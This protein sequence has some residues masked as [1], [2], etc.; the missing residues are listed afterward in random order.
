METTVRLYSPGYRET[1]TYLMAALFIAGNII[2]PQLCHTVPKGGLILLPIYFF[3]LVGSYKYGWLVGML[4]AVLS[5]L[6]NHLLFG[7]PPAA[8]LLPIIIKSVSLAGAAAFIARRTGTATLLSVAATVAIYQF[9]GSLFEWAITGSLTAAMQDI[10][11]GLPGIAIQV[12]GGFAV[13]RYLMR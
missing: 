4:T 2:L 7:M 12:F 8:A 3:T 6:I 13:I 10:S 1:R 9:V 5:P 11:I